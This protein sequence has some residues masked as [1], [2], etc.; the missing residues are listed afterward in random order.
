MKKMSFIPL[1]VGLLFVL[2]ACDPTEKIINKVD[3]G[4]SENASSVEAVSEVETTLEVK[5]E[6]ELMSEKTLEKGLYADITMENGGKIT[7]KLMPEVAPKTVENFQKLASDAF[8]NGLIFHRVIDGF[9]IQ[10]GDPSGTGMGGAEETIVGEFSAN[11][12]ENNLSHKR[13]VISMARSR[14]MDSASSQFFIVHKDSPHLDG[15]Y[16]AFGEVV[17]GMDVVDAIATTETGMA[18]KPVA[19]QVMKTVEVYEVE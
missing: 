11:G 8:Y 9:M 7:I 19:D 5:T 2:T 15:Q 6:E 12:I 14:E 4:L 17:S 10:G 16:A 3:A 13:G 18:D 1:L